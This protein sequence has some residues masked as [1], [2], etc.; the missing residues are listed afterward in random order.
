[1]I[2][3]QPQGAVAAALLYNAFRKEGI[4]GQKEMP[5]D[6]L[7]AGVVQGSIE[8][9]FYI[10]LTVS[11]DYKRDANALWA[12]SRRTFEDPETRYLF[13][14][15][16]I[17]DTPYQ[18]VMADMQK[19][20]L[21]KKQKNDAFIWRTVALTF[22]K[23]CDGNPINFLE[24]CQ[25]K[26]DVILKALKNGEHLYNGKPLLDFPFL[27]GDKI[28]PLW[29]LSKYGCTF[30]NL[31]GYCPKKETCVA[32]DL[33]VQGLVKIDGQSSVVIDT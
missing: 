14:P 29:H 8:H 15:S 13:Y 21:S 2:I 26:A 18:K 11:I 22:L 23:K 16:A 31:E 27:R 7:P 4:H 33:C 28:G 20:S 5:E 12:S 19:Y 24:N 1:M 3:N 25:W 10:T 9:L 6:I 30:R 32:K 17:F